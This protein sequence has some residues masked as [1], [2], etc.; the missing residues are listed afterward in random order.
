[1]LRCY[2][3]TSALM[4]LFMDHS[5]APGAAAAL[6]AFLED[7]ELRVQTSVLTITELR[8]NAVL[9]LEL[10]T[11]EEV[12]D[13]AQ[14]I[15]LIPLDAIQ[16]DRAGMLLAG[17]DEFGNSRSLKSADAVHI[18]AALDHGAQRFVSYDFQQ[19]AAARHNGLICLSPG[20]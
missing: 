15:D 14:R 17:R 4:L 5:K 18:A 9:K 19:I 2:L 20:A 13:L 11:H 1:V 8:R 7:R 3:D 6:V 10:A 12:S 16:A